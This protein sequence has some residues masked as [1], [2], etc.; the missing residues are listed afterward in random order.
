[1]GSPYSTFDDVTKRYNPI[2]QLIGTG[3]LQVTTDDVSSV[4]I[5]DAMSIV[6][7]Y[8]APRYIVP[9]N[10]EPLLTDLTSDIAIYRMLEERLLRV[11]DAFITRY[12]NAM[13]ILGMLRDGYM[14]LTGSSVQITSGGD[15]DAWSNNVS[16]CFDGNVFKRLDRDD[17]DGHFH[18]RGDFF[19]RG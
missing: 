7:G 1:M 5:R 6:D 3:S 12:T 19:N 8:L 16:A 15:Q 9:L 10:P 11:P 18:T 13:S 17:I 14:Q 4:Y 2:L